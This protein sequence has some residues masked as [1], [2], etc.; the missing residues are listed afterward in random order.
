MSRL[1]SENI[2]GMLNPVRLVN[3][4]LTVFPSCPGFPIHTFDH[5]ISLFDLSGFGMEIRENAGGE[6]ERP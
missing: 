4:F 5:N 3:L 2:A 6:C 1:E